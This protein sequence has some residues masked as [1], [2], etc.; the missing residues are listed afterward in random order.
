MKLP[1]F[2]QY[3]KE[4]GRYKWPT[5]KIKCAISLQSLQTKGKRKN[6]MNRDT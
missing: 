1:N 4:E 3:G 5:L 2:Q 6:A